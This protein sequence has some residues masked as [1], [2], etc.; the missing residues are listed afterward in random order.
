MATKSVLLSGL[1]LCVLFLSVAFGSNDDDLCIHSWVK[2]H[3]ENKMRS[4]FFPEDFLKMFYSTDSQ[5][6]SSTDMFSGD[7]ELKVLTHYT[8]SK[9]YCL[10]FK[11]IDEML[12]DVMYSND[13]LHSVLLNKTIFDTLSFHK[14]VVEVCSKPGAEEAGIGHVKLLSKVGEGIR[15]AKWVKV[16][17]Y[18]C[19]PAHCGKTIDE[20]ETRMLTMLLPVNYQPKKS[21][22]YGNYT[23]GA[24]LKK[25][26]ISPCFDIYGERYEFATPHYDT[27]VC[28][29]YAFYD[30]KSPS[31]EFNHGMSRKRSALNEMWKT[32]LLDSKSTNNICFWDYKGL[33]DPVELKCCCRNDLEGCTYKLSNRRQYTRC[34]QFEGYIHSN[35]QFKQTYDRGEPYSAASADACFM[36]LRFFGLVG[37]Q[38]EFQSGAATRERDQRCL[39]ML[40]ERNVSIYCEVELDD[41]QCPFDMQSKLSTKFTRYCCCRGTDLCNLAYAREIVI[42]MNKT[43]WKEMSTS[44]QFESQNIA[45]KKCPANPNEYLYTE[46]G[47]VQ[48]HLP[49]YERLNLIENH[50]FHVKDYV[51]YGK[52][53]KCTL[54]EIELTK[55]AFTGKTSGGEKCADLAGE[56]KIVGMLNNTLFVLRC[57]CSGG[58]ICN[59]NVNSPEVRAIDTRSQCNEGRSVESDLVNIK[60]HED[61]EPSYC[62]AF[63]GTQSGMTMRVLT[64]ISQS[65]LINSSSAYVTR[66]IDAGCYMEP[67]ATGLVVMCICE[68]REHKPCNDVTFLNKVSSMYHGR[69]RTEV[70]SDDEALECQF[71]DNREVCYRPGCFLTMERNRTK[72]GCIHRSANL[73]TQD[74]YER[75]LCLTT[76]MQ[77]D[78]KIIVPTKGTQKEVHILCCCNGRLN[79]KSEEF[80]EKLRLELSNLNDL[81]KDW[82]LL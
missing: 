37:N 76:G 60:L 40:H 53:S 61:S 26:S 81:M 25:R 9:P 66:G 34:F 36:T 46:K 63:M 51:E 7:D 55:N 79:C 54:L 48:Y 4:T 16:K 57:K 30:A 24:H 73:E 1:L 20:I 75:R 68:S 67:S 3:S 22:F 31:Y 44:N 28:P 10:Y 17:W 42:G 13:L 21:N 33:H 80:N 11:S 62:A 15:R 59:F 45:L 18:C 72:S 58:K 32:C 43:V 71:D 39:R 6:W 64:G 14:S 82:K 23:A 49:N 19:R 8:S 38:M 12:K 74:R 47:C 70:S 27:P 65:Q 2:K 41:I 52:F 77:N 5:N 35:G 29:V 78:C 50:N 56:R 69:S